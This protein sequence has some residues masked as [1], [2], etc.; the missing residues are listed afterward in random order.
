MANP[1]SGNPRPYGAVTVAT[2][3]TP[4]RATV[5]QS[6]PTAR[7]GLQSIRFQVLPGNTGVVYVRMKAG[8]ADDRTVLTVTLAILPAPASA[9][10]GPFAAYEV[11]PSGPIGSPFNLADFYIDAAVNTNGVLISGIAG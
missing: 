9:T 8:L 3:G 5:N 6:D 11:A 4:V 7:V 10:S 1:Q 2:G